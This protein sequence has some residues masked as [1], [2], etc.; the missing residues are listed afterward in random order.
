MPLRASLGTAI[1]KGLLT[2]GYPTTAL[3]QTSETIVL[4]YHAIGDSGV[5]TDQFKSQLDYLSTHFELIFASEICSPSQ[6]DGLRVA[7][8]FD[9]GLRNTRDVALPIMRQL[10]IKSTL[11][12]LPCQLSWLWPAEVR[13]RLNA[14]LRTGADLENLGLKDANCIDH[15]VQD[16]K[17]M[18]QDQFQGRLDQIRA[19][20]PFNPSSTWLAVHELM[21]ADELRDLPTDLVEFGAH[22]IHHPILPSLHPSD[23]EREIVDCRD[24]LEILLERPIKTFS[25]PN[26]DF[27]KRCLDLVEQHYDAAFTTES[28]I[29]TYPDQAGIRGHRHAINRLHGV[30]RATDLP[31]K[32]HQFINQGHGFKSTDEATSAL[33]QKRAESAPTSTTMTVDG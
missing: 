22:T 15:I 8:T 29:G 25:Y 23:L 32:M 30:D 18:P 5:P 7:I 20:T 12:V 13:E 1:K 16:L 6:T 11:F 10:G 26:G 17:T 33:D 21:N 19:V 24:Q 27:D 3:K 14:A 31:L 9:D 4:F 2:A 28:A